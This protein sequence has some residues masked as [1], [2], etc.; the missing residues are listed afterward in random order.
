MPNPPALPDA[1]SRYRAILLLGPTGSGKTPL[2]EL[3]ERRGLW[4][5][6]CRHFDFGANLREIVANNRP[7]ERISASEIKF[8]RSVLQSGA[9]LEDEHFLLAARIL[10]RFLTAKHVQSGDWLVLNGLPRHAGQAKALEGI[11]SVEAVIR[12]EC[13]PE[14]VLERIRTNAGGDRT[15]RQDDAPEDVARKLAVFSARTASLV[16]YYQDRGA[17][18]KLSL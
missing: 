8:L 2:G 3:L 5:H 12:L 14:T 7:D 15:E 11:L 1:T 10:D 18:S 13:M 4:G 9:L 17:G 16:N 6:A